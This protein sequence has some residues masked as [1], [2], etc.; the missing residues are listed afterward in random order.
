MVFPADHPDLSLRGQPKGMKV[1]LQERESV[2]D[3]LMARCKGKVGGKCKDCSKSQAKKDAERRVAEVEAMGQEET[4]AEEL[5][6]QAQQP[7]SS[8]PAS[9]WCCMYRVLTLQEDFATKKPMLQHYIEGRGH[10]CMFLPKFHCEL[11]PIEMLWGYAKYRESLTVVCCI[12]VEASLSTGFHNVSDGKFVTARQLV[13]RCLDMCETITI[14]C[15]FWKTW[16][17]MDAYSCVVIHNLRALID[18]TQQ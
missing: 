2:W 3:E 10:K 16:R 13:P 14:R 6:V 11:N 4:L 5:I 18:I 7:E 1:V 17:Y 8:E 15:F 12:A 9:E